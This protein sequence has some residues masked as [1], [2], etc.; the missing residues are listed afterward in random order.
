MRTIL[1]IS[2]LHF[3]KTDPVVITK[4][5]ESVVA[6]DADV[7]VVSGDL[8]QRAKEEQFKD[9]KTFLKAIEAGGAHV[10]VIPGNHD[11]RPVYAPIKRALRPYD[12]YKEYIAHDTEPRYLYDEIAIGSID[13]VR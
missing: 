2:D 7:V 3:G 10:F 6:V 9:V 5:L 12:R 1:H 8:T 11:I 4:L 13:T